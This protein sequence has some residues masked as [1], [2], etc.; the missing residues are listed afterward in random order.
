MNEL[1]QNQTTILNQIQQIDNY[2]HH[3]FSFVSESKFDGILNSLHH[4]GQVQLTSGHKEYADSYKATNLID[5]SNTGDSYYDGYTD[6]DTNWFEFRLIMRKIDLS[7]YQL[8]HL[9]IQLAVL[10]QRQH[11]YQIRRIHN[12]KIP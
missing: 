7:S 1:H 12:I 11:Y 9:V 3:I 8:N 10:I 2:F 4:K 6:K 5:Y